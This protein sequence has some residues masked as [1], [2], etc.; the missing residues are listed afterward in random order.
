MN[1]NNKAF[2]IVE[3]LSVIVLMSIILILSY[4][5]FSNMSKSAKSKYDNSIEVLATSA[6][7]MYV[8]NNREEIDKYFLTNSESDAK[9][10]IPLG[11]LSAYDYIDIDSFIEDKS[12]SEERDNIMRSCVNVE[13]TTID[14]K[15]KFVYKLSDTDKVGVDIDYLPPVLTITKKEGSSLECNTSIN[16]SS[17]DIYDSNCEVVA[18]DNIDSNIII[19]QEVKETDSDIIIVYTA[20]DSSGNNAKPLKVRLII[21]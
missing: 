8:S 1:K 10:C 7:K 2:T 13:K 12:N 15:T 3:L 14:G 18:Y 11:K 16:I 19:N 4:P 17:K 6:A 20:S 21:E 5:N 9:Y